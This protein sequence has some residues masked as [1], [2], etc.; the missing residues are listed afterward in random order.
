MESMTGNRTL[1][2]V[3][4]ALGILGQLA[5]A[6]WFVLWPALSVPSPFNYLIVATWFVLVGLTIAW[7]RHH[8]WRSFLVPIISVP[9][10]ILILNFGTLNWGWVP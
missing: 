7:W 10:I 6:Y 8:P 9:V 5:A 1:A 2:S 3:A 4:G